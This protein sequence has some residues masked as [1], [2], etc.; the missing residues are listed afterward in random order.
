M[1]YLITLEHYNSS[2]EPQEN[3]FHVLYCDNPDDIG[4]LTKALETLIND[5]LNE[6]VVEWKDVSVI[7][8]RQPPIVSIE[9]PVC[10]ICGKP[11][12][13]GTK[14]EIDGKLWCVDCDF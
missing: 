5:R 8:D 6:G 7:Q 14:P 3:M 13:K 1:N 4:D 9:K 2:G 10:S 11:V 12:V